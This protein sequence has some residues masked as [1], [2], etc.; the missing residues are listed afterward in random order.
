MRGS[1]PRSGRGFNHECGIGVCRGLIRVV[2]VRHSGARR[3]VSHAGMH[4]RNAGADS[5]KRRGTILTGSCAVIPR[6]TDQGRQPLERTCQ[7]RNRVRQLRTLGSVGVGL[8]DDPAYPANSVT[9]P[10]PPKFRQCVRNRRSH[11]LAARLRRVS[12]LAQSTN[13]SMRTETPTRYRPQGES[14]LP[15]INSRVW[16]CPWVPVAKRSLSVSEIRDIMT[17]LTLVSLSIVIVASA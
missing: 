2:P 3:Y 4:S 15:M 5:A 16:P 7:V 8:G 12:G 14:T 10:D 6:P 9:P 11:K 13:K 1:H 17:S